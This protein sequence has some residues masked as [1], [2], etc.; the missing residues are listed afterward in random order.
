MCSAINQ[1]YK[2]QLEAEQ[3]ELSSNCIK[4]YQA[5]SIFF[6]L[7]DLEVVLFFFNG[8]IEIFMCDILFVKLELSSII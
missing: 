8:L 5:S 4:I 6:F 1:L 2:R 7:S 3:S